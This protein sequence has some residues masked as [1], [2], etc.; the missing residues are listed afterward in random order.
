MPYCEIK[1]DV[2]LYYD[3][4]GSGDRYLLCTQIGNGMDIFEEMAEEACRF[5]KNWKETGYYYEPV[6]N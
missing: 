1:P 2:C 5:Y 6:V 4:Y 3:E